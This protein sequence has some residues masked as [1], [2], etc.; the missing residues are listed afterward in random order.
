MCYSSTMKSTNYD[1]EPEVWVQKVENETIN[2]TYARLR[3]NA[4]ERDELND[5]LLEASNRVDMLKAKMNVLL[6]QKQISHKVLWD[7]IYREY[8]DLHPGI[9]L[10]IEE[11]DHHLMIVTPVPERK[12]PFEF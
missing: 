5:E 7:E 11:E 8:P 10:N 4:I 1:S 2:D 12:N 3:I 6:A 9:K